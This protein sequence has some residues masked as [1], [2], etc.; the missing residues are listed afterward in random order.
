MRMTSSYASRMAKNRL[1]SGR[2]GG[3][4]TDCLNQEYYFKSQ[5]A[6]KE[7]F[8]DLP[9]AIASIT[10]IL[11][12]I[13]PY[14]LNRDVLLPNLP[15]LRNSCTSRMLMVEKGGENAYLRHLTYEGAK[16]ATPNLQEIT[17]RVDFELEVIANTGYPGYFLIV[18]DFYS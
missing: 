8:K 7:L 15:S 12:K 5:D 18:Q 3:I 16:S 13:E 4:V 1:L 14:T 17:D 9:Q 11:Q 2:E 6:M 10:E